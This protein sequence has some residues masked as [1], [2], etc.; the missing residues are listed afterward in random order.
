MYC[1]K[2]ARHK[3]TD[4]SKEITLPE[5]T[6]VLELGGKVDV[7]YH[8]DF[9]TVMAYQ[10]ANDRNICLIASVKDISSLQDLKHQ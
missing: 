2:A 10:N 8:D 5:S 3:N 6:M 1:S 7:E 9:D 4:D